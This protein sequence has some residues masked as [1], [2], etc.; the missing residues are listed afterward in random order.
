MLTILSK[1]AGMDR[2]HFWRLMILAN[3]ELGT[4]M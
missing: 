2:S 1:S 4:C 3:A